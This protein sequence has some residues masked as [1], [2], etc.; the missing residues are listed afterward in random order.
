[1]KG[2]AFVLP[3][4]D[5]AGTQR[6]L[7]HRPMT[8]AAPKRSVLSGLGESFLAVLVGNIIYFGIAPYLPQ[9]LQ[10]QL[11]RPDAGLVLDFLICAVVF[12]IIRLV[13]KKVLTDGKG[14]G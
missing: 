9:E 13:R 7:E 5:T 10:H 2:P 3:R 8:S 1:M 4:L 11:F 14:R 6:A 12:G